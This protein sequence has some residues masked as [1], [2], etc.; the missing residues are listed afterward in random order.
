MKNGG[1]IHELPLGLL[2]SAFRLSGG[3]GRAPASGSLD[4]KKA[5]ERS[6]RFP[7]WLILLSRSYGQAWSFSRVLNSSVIG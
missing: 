4:N 7:P 5:K 2:I 6:L 3:S 1:A